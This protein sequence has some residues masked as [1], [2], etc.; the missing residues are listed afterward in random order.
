MFWHSDYINSSGIHF[1]MYI[2]NIQVSF[3]TYIIQ[4]VMSF[5]IRQGQ[6]NYFCS[7]IVKKWYCNTQDICNTC[8]LKTPTMHINF[9]ILLCYQSAIRKT[10]IIMLFPLSVIY[11]H[12]TPTYT[13][14]CLYCKNI[15]CSFSCFCKKAQ[16]LHS[17]E[18]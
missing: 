1:H 16:K 6:I 9:Y 18:L 2:H 15:I 17:E 12:E 11:G 14:Q 8:E 5:K 7:N 3:V 10:Y 4:R 13:F